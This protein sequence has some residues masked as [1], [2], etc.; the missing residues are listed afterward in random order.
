M[1][2]AVEGPVHAVAVSEE[3]AAEA[4]I[5]DSGQPTARSSLSNR[6]RQKLLRSTHDSDT[7][8][9]SSTLGAATC[10]SKP[11]H[12]APEA[13]RT[14]F[15][16]GGLGSG[17]I[18]TTGHGTVFCRVD[19]TQATARETDE[20]DV[21]VEAAPCEDGTA[22]AV[23]ATPFATAGHLRLDLS[24]VREA[25]LAMATPGLCVRPLGSAEGWGLVDC[26]AD[27]TKGDGLMPTSRVPPPLGFS[28]VDDS[29]AD[30][31]AS[32][33]P[34]MSRSESGSDDLDTT[35]DSVQLPPGTPGAAEG[36]AA[37]QRPPADAPQSES[38]GEAGEA[39]STAP[40]KGG[41]M[42]AAY[43]AAA[44]RRRGRRESKRDRSAFRRLSRAGNET[45]PT[46][47]QI[48]LEWVAG[49]SDEDDEDVTVFVSQR[50]RRGQV[51]VS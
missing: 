33:S 35:D 3:A 44:G 39:E 29:D 49:D 46:N 30:S 11:P 6:L 41:S 2:S 26:I 13:S 42:W 23:D 25:W 12:H 32:M 5:K 8:A 50:Q 34:R 36:A 48:P 18:V 31:T 9:S 45:V 4:D 10:D 51:T 43:R 20:D 22:V 16:V 1:N 27:A 19:C 28:I 38:V 21:D 47:T 15:V 14:S 24:G 7:T 40:R 17:I 37:N